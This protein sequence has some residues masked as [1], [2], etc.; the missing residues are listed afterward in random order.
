M[1]LWKVEVVR[2]CVC[3]CVWVK[4]ATDSTLVVRKTAPVA[5]D[6]AYTADRRHVCTWLHLQS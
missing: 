5:A 4:D 6:A 1:A 3:V 2:V